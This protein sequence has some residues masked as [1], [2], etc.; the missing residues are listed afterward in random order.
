MKCTCDSMDLFK[1]GCL[2]GFLEREKNTGSSVGRESKGEKSIKKCPICEE[3]FPE[4][5]YNGHSCT[6]VVPF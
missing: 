1:G 2:C 6:Y 5:D 4:D 3:F